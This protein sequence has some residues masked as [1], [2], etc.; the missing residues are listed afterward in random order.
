MIKEMEMDLVQRDLD[1]D[2]TL[3]EKERLRILLAK[4]P[5]LQLM[6]DRLQKVSRQLADLPPVTPAFNLVD[7]ILP[8]LQ[9]D[10]AKPVPAMPN[11][12]REELPTLEWKP[13]EEPVAKKPLI[14]AWFTKVGSGVAAACLLFGLFFLMKGAIL[15]KPGPG[16]Q[17]GGTVVVNPVS[18]E[19]DPPSQQLVPAVQQPVLPTVPPQN[20]AP[21]TNTPPKKTQP[22]PKQPTVAKPAV[23]AKK[24]ASKPAVA[25]Q[26][27]VPSDR[28]PI[29]PGAGSSMPGATSADIEA[30]PQKKA[31]KE[32]KKDAGKS[33]EA[34]EPQSGDD[35]K[36][37]EKKNDDK[38]EDKKDDKQDDKK[39]DK[40]NSPTPSQGSKENAL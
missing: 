10:L 6:H 35:E 8:M 30:A 1:G 27:A 32:E 12:E 20:P 38:Q 11:L 24:L 7:S 16:S 33:E 4:N 29:F 17:T 5:E 39:E 28:G 3:A 40:N 31:E 9:S 26:P 25:A 37:K 2:L 18:T 21:K 15:N 23:P 13:R 22:T 36:E 14:P 19:P 34:K